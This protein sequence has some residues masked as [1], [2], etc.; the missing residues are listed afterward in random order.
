MLYSSVNSTNILFVATATLFC[1]VSNRR[2]KR[3]EFNQ[4]DTYAEDLNIS[5]RGIK[6]LQPVLPYWEGFIRCLNDPC[7]L[8]FNQEGY[9]ALCVAENKLVQESFARRLMQ[10]AT[11]INAFSDSIVYGYSSFLGLPSVREAA[12]VSKSLETLRNALILLSH[13]H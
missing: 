5:H 9:I 4:E 7:D 13:L 11:A 2:R 3:H 10:P 12:A 6:S 8:N 1:L